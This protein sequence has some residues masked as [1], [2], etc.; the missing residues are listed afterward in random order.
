MKILKTF[1]YLCLLMGTLSQAHAKEYLVEIVVFK[2]GWGERQGGIAWEPGILAPTLSNVVNIHRGA[3]GGFSPEA[4]TR[5]AEHAAAIKASKE[6]DLL[7]HMAWRQPDQ[8]GSGATGVRVAHGREIPVYIQSEAPVG[9]FR[10]YRTAQFGDLLPT[11]SD[12]GSVITQVLNGS[13]TLSVKRYLHLKTDLYYTQESAQ[14][15]AHIQAQR[16]MRSNEVHYI[17]H[18]VVGIIAFVTPVK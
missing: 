7:A 6:F 8:S 10:N 13:V 14:R 11:G 17:D 12:V 15:S 2:H 16:R 3:S 4:G 18:P 9:A 1:A 5:L